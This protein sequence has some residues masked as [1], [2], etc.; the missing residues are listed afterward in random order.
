M[1]VKIAVQPESDRE[2]VICRLIDAPPE[3]VYQG[4]TRPELLVQWFAPK[5]WTTARAELD[6]RPGGSTLVVMKSPEGVEMPC[7]GVYLE[8]IP[9]KKLVFTDAFTSAW[10]PAEKPFMTVILMFENEGG[11][12]KYTARVLHANAKDCEEHRKMG[13]EEGWGKCCDQLE[14]LVRS[15]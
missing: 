12:T 13:F 4:W 8:V 15:L 7:P 9:G 3:K 10:Q 11:K 2:L 5:P 1:S 6:V 14:T